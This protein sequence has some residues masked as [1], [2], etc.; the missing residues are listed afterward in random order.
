MMQEPPRKPHILLGLTGS[1]AA[2][3]GEEL[4][5]LLSQIGIVRIV[6]TNAAGHFF[7]PAALPPDA[8]AFSD[9][10]EWHDWA[11]KGD[12]V[13]HIELRKWADIFVIAPLSA[14]TLAKIANG[15]CDNLLVR[16]LLGSSVRI[17]HDAC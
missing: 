11:K 2:I 13:L 16:S 5:G 12:P 6:A 7:K 1:V 14:N 4:V 9:T 15:L 10:T 17:L 8:T 3:K